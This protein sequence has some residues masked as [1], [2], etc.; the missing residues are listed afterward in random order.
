MLPQVFATPM[1]VLAM[2][3]AALNAIRG[4]LDP[5]ESAVGTAVDIRHI[6][7]TP[8]GHEVIQAE[9]QH[10]VAFA[11]PPE[12]GPEERPP[13]EVEGAAR[14]RS[15]PVPRPAR[16]EDRSWIGRDTRADCEMT[17]TSRSPCG[18]N[19]VL[20]ISWRRL[21]QDPLEPPVRA[22]RRPAGAPAA[23]TRSWRD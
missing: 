5:G 23:S 16:Q 6:A 4:Y 3:N 9:Q 10:V 14:A 2:E 17:C 12:A 18:E 21:V 1:M 22:P 13:A 8:V 20:R 19:V 7:A 15:K 11:K